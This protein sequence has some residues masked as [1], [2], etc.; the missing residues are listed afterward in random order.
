V[1]LE[2]RDFVA[3]YKTVVIDDVSQFR[4]EPKERVGP[5][6][7]YLK[8]EARRSVAPRGKNRLFSVYNC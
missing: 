6:A 1:I 3:V 2:D 7:V 5:V 4:R 8:G